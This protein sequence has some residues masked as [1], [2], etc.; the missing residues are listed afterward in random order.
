MASHIQGNQSRK[1]KELQDVQLFFC[2]LLKPL[3]MFILIVFLIFVV[4]AV[5]INV[6]DAVG[7]P[8]DCCDKCRFYRLLISNFLRQADVVLH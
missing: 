2:I 6:K 3:T 7:K 5:R 4:V 8:H 1:R